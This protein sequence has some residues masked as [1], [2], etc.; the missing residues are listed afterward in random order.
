METGKPILFN[1]HLARSRKAEI[2]AVGKNP[3]KHTGKIPC[4]PLV[5]WWYIKS[6]CFSGRMMRHVREIPF[7]ADR[8]KGNGNPD[9]KSTPNDFPRP[10]CRQLSGGWQV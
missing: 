3:V 7:N 4:G 1:G 2:I 8:R 5:G 10:I 6:I 9:F